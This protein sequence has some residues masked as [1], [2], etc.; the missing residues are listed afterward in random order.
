M[1][2]ALGS[3][4]SGPG[5]SLA[6]V[7]ASVVFKIEQDSL[8]SYSSTSLLSGVFMGTGELM[9]GDTEPRDGLASYPG[10][11]KILLVAFCYKNRDKLKLVWATWLDTDCTLPTLN[12]VVQIAI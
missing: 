2:N 4:S 7:V 12:L 10:G 11:V 5:L 1:V 3:G 6:R 8:L 9:L